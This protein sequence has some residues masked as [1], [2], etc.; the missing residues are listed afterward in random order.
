M[1]WTG[2]VAAAF[3]AAAVA[4]ALMVGTAGPA[5]ASGSAGRVLG[6]GGGGRASEVRAS[7][8]RASEGGPAL[9]EPG[10]ALRDSVVCDG[11]LGGG[12]SDPVLLIPGT[13]LDPD[14]NFDWNYEPALRAR[15]QAYCAVRLPGHAMADIQTAAEYV[16]NAL[17]VM[18]RRAQ[19]PVRIVGFSQGGM[20]GR[21]ALKY[22]P[23]TRSIV[24]ELIGID[25]SNHG[26]LDAV[27]LCALACAPAFWQQRTGSAFLTALNDGP[28]TYPGISYTQIYSYTDEV[29]VPNLPPAASSSLHTGEG[30]IANIAVQQICPGHLADHLSMGSIDPVGY[31][32]VIDALTHDGPARAARIDRSVC[33]RAL[34][35]GVDPAALPANEARYSGQV[36]TV[37]ATYPP[38][39]AE[40]ALRPYAR[41]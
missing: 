23:D 5:A 32:L 25:P 31:A 8:V 27:P 38:V 18:Q 1:R 15:H 22:W 14:V 37:A 4:A 7:E 39:F 2:R 21:W 12:A 19:R 17:R 33:T 35:P 40:P 30:D 9:R 13:T 11:D 26:T 36:G 6:S 3:G 34:M 41:D 16:V 29:V 10:A 24:G 20:I 28:E